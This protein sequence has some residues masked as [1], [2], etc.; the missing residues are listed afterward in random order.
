MSFAV[1]LQDSKVSDFKFLSCFKCCS[2]VLVTREF[3][4]FRDTSCVKPAFCAEKVALEIRK[5]K[6]FKTATTVH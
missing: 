6:S 3:E 4:T 2:P 1:T 5:S